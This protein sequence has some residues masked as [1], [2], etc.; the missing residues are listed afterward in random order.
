MDVV[1]VVKAYKS[2]DYNKSDTQIVK[3]FRSYENAK[4]YCE[5][6]DTTLHKFDF[7]QVII[8]D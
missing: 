8:S 6:Q 3:V 1:Y 4:R 2:G 5:S 7:E